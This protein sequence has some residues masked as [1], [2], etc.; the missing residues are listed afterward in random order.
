MLPRAMRVPVRAEWRW[1]AVFAVLV[2]ALT[3]APYVAGALAQ[4]GEWRFSGFLIGVEDGNSYIAKM[5]Q[6]ARGGWLF[7]LPYSSEPQTGAFV[8]IFYLVLGKLSG[9]GHTARVLTFHLA[10]VVFG[11]LLLVISYRFLAEFLPTVTQ[12]R[13]GLVLVAL[14]GGL[15]WLVVML[16]QW[17]GPAMDLFAL[18]LLSPEA[19]SFLML[20][21]LP[22][23]AA[24]RCLFLLALLAHLRGRGAWTGAAL[25]GVSLIQPLYVIVAWIVMGADTLAVLLRGRK[26]SDG[27]DGNRFHSLGAGLW[28]T[29]KGPAWAVLISSPVVVYS[30]FTFNADPVLRQWLAQNILTSP[31]PVNYLLGYGALL[32]PALFGW[33]VLQRERPDLAR[34]VAVWALLLPVLLY[35]PISTQRRMIEG[36]QL[37]LVA[38]AVLGLTATWRRWS[39]LAL[40]LTLVLTL[41][42]TALLVAGGFGAAALPSEPIFTSADRLR[43][44]AWLNENAAPGEVAL[45]NYEIGNELPVY[46]PLVAY[47]GHG[48][49]TVFLAQKQ[50][51]VASFFDNTGSD[52]ERRALLVDGRI[53]YVV[54]GPHN[55]RAMSS[56]DPRGAEY[57]RPVYSSGAY[58]VY[59][60]HLSK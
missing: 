48:P 51:R 37:P 22:H 28:N 41:P 59:R 3:T 36:F 9:A 16:Q 45:S 33:R 18:D 50:P 17:L 39:R 14:G 55:R 21:S 25:F 29:V 6:G 20:F 40:P 56:F 54:D 23:L 43:A 15:T 42:T 10:R 46:T 19:F 12:R 2:M 13:L 60:V 44:F 5:G 49:E 11:F 58:T 27:T 8:Y 52:A 4:T 30:L 53:S 7:R 47:I 24:A 34:F 26:G 31:H 57:L 32:L 1:A 35:L 38:A